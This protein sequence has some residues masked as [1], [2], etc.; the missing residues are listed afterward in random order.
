MRSTSCGVVRDVES[1]GVQTESIAARPDLYGG[2]L[3]HPSLRTSR[4]EGRGARR[5]HD[6]LRGRHDLPS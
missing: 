4:G 6:P 1:S 3:A 5:R 2:R